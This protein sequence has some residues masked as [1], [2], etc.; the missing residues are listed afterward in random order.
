MDIM[1]R[2]CTGRLP[3]ITVLYVKVWKYV[4]YQINCFLGYNVYYYAQRK[5]ERGMD[6]QDALGEVAASRQVWRT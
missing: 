4:G 5:E 6:Q 3:G 1:Y 2:W